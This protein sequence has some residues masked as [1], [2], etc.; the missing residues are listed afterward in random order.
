MQDKNMG[1]SRNLQQSE[2][3]QVVMFRKQNK[4]FAEIAK[5]INR[6]KTVCKQA[7]Y[8]FLKTGVYSDRL[9][10]GRPRKTTPK[11][12]RRINRLSE[13]DR[14]RSAIDIAA[15]INTNNDIQ[16]SART[17]GRRYTDF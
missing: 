1:K 17:V 12:D 6:S 8:K 13:E 4:T 3:K 5:Y 14:F 7:W 2:R 9:K 11:M 10:N 16:I 15:E